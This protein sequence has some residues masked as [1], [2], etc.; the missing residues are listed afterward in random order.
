MVFERKPA[1]YARNINRSLYNIRIKSFYR[2]SC[3]IVLDSK[4][5]RAYTVAPNTTAKNRLI[6]LKKPAYFLP[7]KSKINASSSMPEALS[8]HV[9][10]R[11]LNC[12]L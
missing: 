12:L 7:E 11:A 8:D 3:R 9:T 4:Y 2:F 6:F 1:I 5:L 10:I